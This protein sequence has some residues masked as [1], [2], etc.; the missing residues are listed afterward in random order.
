MTEKK[1]PKTKIMKSKPLIIT[2]FSAS[3]FLLGCNQAVEPAPKTAAAQF[4]KITEETKEAAQEI[5]DYAYAQKAEFVG[6]MQDQLDEINRDLDQLAA[7]TA[8]S[9][10]KAKA[11]AEPKLQALRDQSAKLKK[12]L[13]QAGNATEPA[14]ANIKTGFKKGYDELKDGFQEARRWASDKIAP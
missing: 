13:E 2:L 10:D 1:Y 4:E 8:K 11:E 14:W 7:K 12:Q 5:K 3:A 9:G 6:K